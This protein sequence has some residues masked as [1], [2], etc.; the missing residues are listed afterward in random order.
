MGKHAESND[1]ASLNEVTRRHQKEMDEAF[2]GLG[3]RGLGFGGF[4]FRACA[5]DGYEVP[6]V[7]VAVSFRVSW[8]IHVST[9]LQPESA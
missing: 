5:Y 6:T 7:G 9:Y 3:F 1:K 4:G 8:S 2:R